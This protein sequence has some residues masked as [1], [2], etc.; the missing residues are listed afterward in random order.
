MNKLSREARSQILGLMVEGMSIRA[1]SRITGASKNTIM[2]LLADAGE[3][4]L[5]PVR[6]RTFP[7]GSV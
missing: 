4:L 7:V 6:A 2:K 5:N 3:Y 1:M